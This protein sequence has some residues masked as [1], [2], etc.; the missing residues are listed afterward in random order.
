M[1]E[2]PPRFC[3]VGSSLSAASRLSWYVLALIST[4]GSV[5]SHACLDQ[6]NTYVRVGHSG[7][8]SEPALCESSRPLPRIFQQPS[9]FPAVPSRGRWQYAVQLRSPP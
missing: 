2:S 6:G 9:A 4:G 7:I 1:L 5:P 8:L 3:C